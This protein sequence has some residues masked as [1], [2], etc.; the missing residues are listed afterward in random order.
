MMFE[1]RQV[2]CQELTDPLNELGLNEGSWS[3]TQCTVAT[4]G[5]CD[6]AMDYW[7][8]GGPSGTWEMVDERLVLTTQRYNPDLGMQETIISDPIDYCVMG[9]TVRFGAALNTVWPDAAGVLLTRIDCTD[10]VQGPGEDGIDCGYF[11]PNECPP[12]P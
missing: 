4:D 8:V 2:T 11:C 1:G 10:G 5:G 9:D 3:H 6:C 7:G 12:A